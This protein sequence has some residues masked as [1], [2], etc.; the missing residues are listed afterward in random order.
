MFEGV[1]EE[2]WNGRWWFWTL[3]RGLWK[4]YFYYLDFLCVEKTKL[5]SLR[6][7]GVELGTWCKILILAEQEIP[8]STFPRNFLVATFPSAHFPHSE[9]KR[10]CPNSNGAEMYAGHGIGSTRGRNYTPPDLEV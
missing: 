8:R 10:G 9:Y 1:E 7:R 5:T 2:W 3:M 6:L 4:V